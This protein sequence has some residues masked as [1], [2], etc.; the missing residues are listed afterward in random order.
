MCNC[1]KGS[2][3]KAMLLEAT[4][5]TMAAAPEEETVKWIIQ[6]KGVIVYV[7]ESGRR[8]PVR[9]RGESVIIKTADRPGFEKLGYISPRE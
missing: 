9:N 5:R 6:P 1:G 4:R 7:G 8:Y 2:K 3:V